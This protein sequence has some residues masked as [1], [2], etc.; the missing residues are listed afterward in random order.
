VVALRNRKQSATGD[1]G[2]K[3]PRLGSLRPLL[4]A[5]PLGSLAPMMSRGH[6]LALVL[7]KFISF[8]YLIEIRRLVEQ[9]DEMHPIVARIF[10]W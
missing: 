8:F 2:P 4:V 5:I 3:P 6:N 9:F 7:P 10:R 1:D